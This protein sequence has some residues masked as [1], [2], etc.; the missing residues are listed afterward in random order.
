MEMMLSRHQSLTQRMFGDLTRQVEELKEENLR[1]RLLQDRDEVGRVDDLLEEGDA[2]ITSDNVASRELVLANESAQ[3]LH[4]SGPA[5]STC[6]CSGNVIGQDLENTWTEHIDPI[7]NRTF[8]HN[9]YKNSC[10]WKRY[11][12]LFRAQCR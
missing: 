6:N 3:H 4:A 12:L 9:T 8:W 7:T 5:A 1:L 11:M 10:S 2:N